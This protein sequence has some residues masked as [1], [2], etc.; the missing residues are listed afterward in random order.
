MAHDP[1]DQSISSA[2]HWPAPRFDEYPLAP[3]VDGNMPAVPGLATNRISGALVWEPFRYRLLFATVRRVVRVSMRSLARR[4]ADQQDELAGVL[5]SPW[6]P[7][8]T[9][10]YRWA[11]GFVIARVV[12]HG[13]V[14]IILSLRF[15]SGGS[16][17]WAHAT[18]ASELLG[19]LDRGPGPGSALHVADTF[20]ARRTLF[21]E[22]RPVSWADRGVVVLANSDDLGLPWV[23]AELAAHRCAGLPAIAAPPATVEVTEEGWFSVGGRRFPVAIDLRTGGPGLSRA[24]L[25]S[26]SYFPPAHSALLGALRT[27][28]LAS[29]DIAEQ[30][31]EDA[32]TITRHVARTMS[33]DVARR[34]AGQAARAEDDLVV[35][36]LVSPQAR[37][38]RMIRRASTSDRDWAAALETAARDRG[39][40]V[41]VVPAPDRIPVALTSGDVTEV[42]AVFD[43]F[44]SGPRGAGAVLLETSAGTSLHSPDLRV[45]GLV[46]AG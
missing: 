42:P 31:P 27:L 5:G 24:I 45:S 15:G 19:S 16:G 43:V 36:L 11:A 8:P 39:S 9:A 3:G 26:P 23:R 35:E 10:S 22:L 32:A 7:P 25:E 46:A 40:A 34:T 2:A 33:P 13:G 38:R 37:G 12:L 18:L 20:A 28:V 21:D 6:S 30:S 14:P 29:E 1:T 4:G 17:P 44:V 41:Q